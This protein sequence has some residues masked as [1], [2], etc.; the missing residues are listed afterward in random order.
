MTAVNITTEQ[1]FELYIEL[2]IGTFLFMF[3]S[4]QCI[5]PGF[6]NTNFLDSC[7]LKFLISWELFQKVAMKVAVFLGVC[8]DEIE[9]SES[10]DKKLRIFLFVII[11]EL[12]V[13]K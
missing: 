5:F 1:L 7:G 4:L 12:F 10:C 3:L 6:W 11:I 13:E 2:I 8:C 9:A